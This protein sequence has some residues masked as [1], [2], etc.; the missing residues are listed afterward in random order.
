MLC[1]G[2]ALIYP[3]AI[4]NVL[5]WTRGQQVGK[6]KPAGIMRS[7][8]EREHEWA[9]RGIGRRLYR[10]MVERQS[11]VNRLSTCKV[12]MRERKKHVGQK[13]SKYFV[14]F[15]KHVPGPQMK[16]RVKAASTSFSAK[17]ASRKKIA[18]GCISTP[19][20]SGHVSSPSQRVR[21][22]SHDPRCPL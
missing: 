1:T 16:R 14:A 12:T 21:L 3:S 17:P 11:Q 13:M 8:C 18:S 6:V 20:D 19:V 7:V 5:P 9:S 15:L 2:Q 10:F 22:H 4:C